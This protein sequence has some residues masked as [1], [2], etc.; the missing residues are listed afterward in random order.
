MTDNSIGGGTASGMVTFK[1]G[2]TVLGTGTLDGSGQATY[3]SNALAVGNHGIAATFAGDVT[4][5]PSVSPGINYAVSGKPVTL[6]GLVASNKVYNGTT[7]ALLTGGTVSG[8]LGGDTVT[9]IAGTGTFANANAGTWAVTVSG[10]AL[11]GSSAGNYLLSAQ[12][13]ATNASITARPVVLTGTR[14]YD[15]TV[16][17]SGLGVANNLDGANLSVTGSTSL[18]GKDVGSQALLINYTTPARVRSATGFSPASSSTSFTVTMGAAPANGNTLV[19]VI[20]S[21]GVAANQIT[22]IVSTGATWA[23]VAQSTNS[24]GST[25]EIWS[26]SVATGAAPGVTLSTVAGRCAAVVTEYSG[27]LTGSA[28]DQIASSLG[29]TSTSPL[30]GTTPTTTQGKELWIGGIG[31]RSSAPVLGTFLNSF[32]SVASAQSTSTTAANNAKVYALERIVTASGTASSG[33]T[34]DASVAWSGTIATFKAATT[35]SLTLTGSAA[36]N[37]TLAGLSG[38]VTITPKVLTVTASD[39]SKTYGQT[40][41]FDSDNMQFSSSGLQNGETISSVTLA[42]TGGDAAAAVASYPI[43]PTAAIGG[44]FAEGNY[45]ISYVAGTFTVNMITYAS[46]ATDGAQNLT[47]GVND[48]PSADPDDDGISNLMEFALS[49]APMVCSPAILPTFSKPSADWVFEYNRS[50]AA[51]P[52]TIQEVEYGSDLTGWTPVIIPATT[53][54]IVEI[55]PGSPSDRVRVIIPNL[56]TQTFVRLKVSQ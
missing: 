37:Y 45:S 32:T 11:G 39:Q 23:R 43:T 27:I 12:P 15:G 22:G 33:G 9:V 49:G 54:G 8:V 24:A 40:V 28:V 26:A 47:P 55:T 6:T 46:W 41:T 10:C 30:T 19:A 36:G 14:L 18:V 42:C 21:L 31:Y 56:G 13:T 5:G 35:S 16:A 52:A 1:D 17:A 34:L 4:Y 38:A 3:I 25:T 44:T 7:A 2:A 50:N 48:S 53:A 20:S 51:Q 29:A